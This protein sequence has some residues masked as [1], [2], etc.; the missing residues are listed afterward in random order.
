M[1]KNRTAQIF[2][3]IIA[4][5]YANICM[6][7]PPNEVLK[8][9]KSLFE[10]D[11]ETQEIIIRKKGNKD[12]KLYI[13]LKNNKL[14]INGK[15]MAA[16][17]DEGITINNRKV[18][19]KDGKKITIDFNT[20]VLGDEMNNAENIKSIR[21][22]KMDDDVF[23]EG[24]VTKVFLGVFTENVDNGA[25]ISI[26]ETDSPADKANLKAG[27][28]IY[29]IN[30]D[31]VS[32]TNTLANIITKAKAGETVNV[33]FIRNGK[34]M[35]TKAT[36]IEKTSKFSIN[37]N[38][39]LEMPDGR[40]KTLTVP[41]V[42]GFKDRVNDLNF[43]TKQMSKPR[44]GIKIQ[45]TEAGNAVKVLAVEDGSLSD[46]AGLKKDDLITEIDKVITINTDIARSQLQIIK[47]KSTYPIKILRD[48]KPM[49][50]L[51][52]IPKILK[53]ADL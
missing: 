44:L 22:D 31:K 25:K 40:I 30:D 4:L 29:K 3:C 20:D 48:N 39:S 12:V 27:D 19:V 41:M 36:L 10:M 16:F 33:Y 50:I 8:N 34:E 18:V 35:E 46:I 23:G 28:I 52:V 15:P 17:T 38:Y 47:N 37:N 26:I 6:A 1:K 42:R 51:I 49:D 7:Q 53:T 2:I 43:I 11:A 13:E 9:D 24:S 32:K 14:L 45:D 5:L 21:I